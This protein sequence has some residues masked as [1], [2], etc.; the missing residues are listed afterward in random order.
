MAKY[1]RKLFL[2]SNIKNVMLIIKKIP[3]FINEIVNFFNMPIAHKFLNPIDGKNIEENENNFTQIKFLYFLFLNNKNFSKNK[4]P[5]KGR[6][7]RKILRKIVFE[8]KL[9]D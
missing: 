2:I 1:I 3:L 8:N 9:V 7:K 5:Q 4:T 6:I